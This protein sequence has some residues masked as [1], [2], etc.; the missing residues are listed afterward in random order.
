MFEI[1]EVKVFLLKNPHE[2]SKTRAFAQFT[3]AGSFVV[4]SI[5]VVEGS[6]GMFVGLPQQKGSGDNS[7]EYYDICF[8]IT[9]EGRE[10]IS[11]E[12]LNR[13]TTIMETGVDDSKGG[14]NSA[15]RGEESQAPAQEEDD[16]I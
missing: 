15:P 2:N 5:R 11:S 7:S 6:K 13:Y 9:K 4:K 16:W 8:P 1:T 12:I 3:I 10:Y 14:G